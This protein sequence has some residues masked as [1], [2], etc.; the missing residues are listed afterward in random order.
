MSIRTYRVFEDGSSVAM[1]FGEALSCGCEEYLRC[2]FFE[3]RGCVHMD[4]INIAERKRLGLVKSV[5]HVAL[6]L[7]LTL[8]R[9]EGW[10]TMSMEK[11]EFMAAELLGELD[12]PVFPNWR[13]IHEILDQRVRA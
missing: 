7:I 8:E 13:R 5:Q 1:R 12:V 6:N 10:H 11:A 9:G 3:G 4:A 2:A